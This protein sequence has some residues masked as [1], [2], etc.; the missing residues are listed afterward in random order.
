MFQM[1][2]WKEICEVVKVCMQECQKY[3]ILR[4]KLSYFFMNFY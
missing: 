1:E 3:D 4:F 2:Q